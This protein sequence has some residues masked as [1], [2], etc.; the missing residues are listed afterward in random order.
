MKPTEI[1]KEY[2]NS[3]NSYTNHKA[4]FDPEIRETNEIIEEKANTEYKTYSLLECLGC[5]S[6]LLKIEISRSNSGNIETE[7]YPIYERRKLDTWAK[8]LDEEYYSLLKE[9]YCA[10]NNNLNRLALMGSRTILDILFNEKV[11]DVGGFQKKLN[12]MVNQGFIAKHEKETIQTV[13]DAGNASAHRGFCPEMKHLETVLE[14]IE[15]TLYRL[16]IIHGKA[17]DLKD[18]VPERGQ[19]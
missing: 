15:R 16:Y 5:N 12:E 11:G 10:I 1:E 18:A 9:I 2:C 13:I 17:M 4:L 8:D 6:I 14:V 3:C 19:H 7:F